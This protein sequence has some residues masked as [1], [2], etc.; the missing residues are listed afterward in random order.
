MDN[1]KGLYAVMSMKNT[2]VPKDSSYWEDRKAI[3]RQL[4]T[5]SNQVEWLAKDLG[6]RIIYSDDFI[7]A[8]VVWR[9]SGEPAHEIEK[10]IDNDVITLDGEDPLCDC[11]LE[12]YQMC[13]D[14]GMFKYSYA[15]DSVGK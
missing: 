5:Y 6:A 3:I 10:L 4:N 2:P 7:K 8:D 9:E 14:L 12:T 13:L 1:T 15:I 11:I